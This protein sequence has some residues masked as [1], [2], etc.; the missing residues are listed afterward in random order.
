MTFSSSRTLPGH[1][2][3]AQQL[4]R[5]GRDLTHGRSVVLRE[6]FEE[7]IDEE[8]NILAALTQRRDG[9]VDDV[10]PVEQVLPE[11][12]LHDH[13]AQVAIGRRD[14]PHVDAPDGTV[15]A[16]LL[17]LAGL[18]EPQQQAL[19]PKR[20]LGHFVEEHRPAVGDLEL[21]LL[22]AIGAGEAALHVAEELGLE[23]RL[24]K[25]RA[26][27]RDHG[28]SDPRATRVDGMRDQLLAHT[29]LASDQ[30]LRV[31]PRD[32]INLLR[33]L[34]NDAARANQLCVVVTFHVHTRNPRLPH[35]PSADQRSALNQTT[36][37]P[38]R[39]GLPRGKRYGVT[40]RRN[41]SSCRRLVS[42]IDVNTVP[43]FNSRTADPARRRTWTVGEYD[44]PANAKRNCPL[45]PIG[46]GTSDSTSAPVRLI[47]SSRT[48]VRSCTLH[49]SS[50]GSITLGER[51][52][53][54]G[55]S[56]ACPALRASFNSALPKGT[57]HR[58]GAS[59]IDRSLRVP[60][61]TGSRTRLPSGTAAPRWSPQ[62]A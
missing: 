42:S 58:R 12:A 26:V 53:S 29:A 30:H 28:P 62:P 44:P 20:H 46:N 47:S 15:R 39:P 37:C 13:V 3:L 41:S 16:D 33:Q 4:D 1:E 48:R 59:T 9:Q 17:D 35:F 50:S 32:P 8:R 55:P 49:C 61:A 14:D 11:R 43:R 57:L 51:R 24:R 40:F 23:E 21:A 36:P 34:E 2:Y 7:M 5:V 27:H 19:H 52:R 6:L 60:P 38:T 10:Q 56:A 22:V 18:H 25:A 54:V 31:G 45:A